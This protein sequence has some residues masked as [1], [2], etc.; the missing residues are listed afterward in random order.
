FTYRSDDVRRIKAIT[1]T[2]DK[3]TLAKALNDL[4]QNTGLRYEEMDENILIMQEDKPVSVII[5]NVQADTTIVSG[6]ITNEKG[7][8]LAGAT[9]IIQGQNKSVTTNN[10]GEFRIANT[11]PGKYTLT[12]S[13][14]G[15]QA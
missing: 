6:K 13:Y 5:E 4:L 2:Q 9:V 3:V 1:Y 15:Y 10:E 8:P 7:E 14:V 12:V 11:K